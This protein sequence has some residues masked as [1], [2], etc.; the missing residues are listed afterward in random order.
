MDAAP[1]IDHGTADE[2]AEAWAEVLIDVRDKRS[3][4]KPASTDDPKDVA[5]RHDP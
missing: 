4:R 2:T 5:V 3:A 1:N